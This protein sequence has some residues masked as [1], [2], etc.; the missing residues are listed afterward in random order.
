MTKKANKTAGT[1]TS[2]VR[3]RT[4]A[5]ARLAGKTGPAVARDR[6]DKLQHELQ[7]HQIELGMQNEELRRAQL[8]LEES[9]DRY[10]D[11]YEFAP[12]GYFILYSQG[13][14]EDLNL[15]G[16]R[17]LGKD[18]KTLRRCRFA[19]LVAAK[20]RPL[21]DRHF[22]SALGRDDPDSLEVA[23]ASKEGA[24]RH[25][26]LD[27]R[28]VTGESGPKL[29]VTLTDI[30]A[31]VRMEEAQDRAQA[32]L[33]A[34]LDSLIRSNA[35]LER[36][37]QIVAHDLQEPVRTLVAYS[38][39]LIRAEGDRLSGESRDY[40]N[41]IIDGAWH[42]YHL[43]QG[44]LDHARIS[45]EIGEFTAVDLNAVVADARLQ[46]KEKLERSGAEL[47]IGPLPTVRGDSVQ[48]LQL[49][50]H[51]MSNALKFV[52][53]GQKPVVAITGAVGAGE[54]TLSVKDDGIGVAPKYHGRI[55]E[56]F[57]HLHPVQTYPGTGIGLAL[58]RR[59]VERHHGRIWIESEEGRGADF[60]FTLPLP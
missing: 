33:K 48:L 36:F 46:L 59:I 9:R 7:V 14:I 12:V 25:A 3:Q 37:A 15:T 45:A 34:G 16:A 5:K 55:F 30:S 4:G 6:A 17:L 39:L 50:L 44:L 57:R 41:F 60:R 56:I 13:L 24:C 31:R 8:A 47:R 23:L 27:C 20:D 54:A 29:R 38:Q 2:T 1:T 11:L 43:V 21:W 28:R 22:L 10:A 26:R 32:S 51:L 35:E 18:R 40:A 19:L 53:P 42:L 58:C 49:F 52:P